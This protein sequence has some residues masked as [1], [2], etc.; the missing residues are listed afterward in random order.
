MATQSKTY[1]AEV[2]GSSE[3]TRAVT[4]ESA[5]GAAFIASGIGSLALGLAIVGAETNAS[6][7]TFLTFVGPVGP[8]SGKTTVAV[9]AFFASWVILHFV[10]RDRPIKLSTSFII[11]LVLIVLGVV[12]SFP[13][14]FVALAGG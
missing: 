9:I 1:N 4:L 13:P 6:I 12:L 2:T 11:T 8:L 7:K 14:V 10:F 5:V 3:E